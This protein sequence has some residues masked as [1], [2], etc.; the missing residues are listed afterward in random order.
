MVP[1]LHLGRAMWRFGLR[2]LKGFKI[3]IL[4]SSVGF[5]FF[6]GFESLRIVGGLGAGHF[7]FRF[8]SGCNG[9]AL[10]A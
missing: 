9:A 8:R 10:C 1:F 3:R 7:E 2:V 5:G 6:G 4:R